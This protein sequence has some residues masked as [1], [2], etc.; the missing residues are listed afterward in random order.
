M[1]I[2]LLYKHEWPIN[3]KLNIVIPTVGEI[4]ADEDKYYGLVGSLTASPLDMMVALDDAGIDFTKLNDYD[5]FIILFNGI[6]STDTHLV[7]GDI[8]L[9]KFQLAKSDKNDQIILVDK[10]NDIIIDRAIHNKIATSLRTIHGLKKN[11]RKVNDEDTKKYL[12]ERERLKQQ[13]RKNR[14]TTQMSQL[15]PLIVAMVNTEQYKYNY[16][17][18]L[19]LTIYQFNESVRQIIK[20]VDYDNRMHGIYSGTLSAKDISKDELNWLVH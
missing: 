10:E 16:E 17:E 15:E 12:L 18:T 6:R 7:F 9:S 5:L 2:N 11:I 19:S 1:A 14:N 13:R 4:I 3:S 8:D 20:K